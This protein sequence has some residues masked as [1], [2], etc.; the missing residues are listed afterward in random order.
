[1]IRADDIFLGQIDPAKLAS[2]NNIYIRFN[3]GRFIRNRE[4]K[5]VAT[6][7]VDKKTGSVIR[8]NYISHT[9]N[10]KND[11]DIR[12]FSSISTIEITRQ[13]IVEAVTSLDGDRYTD[14]TVIS[15]VWN[16]VEIS[17]PK[18]DMSPYTEVEACIDLPPEKLE[19]DRLYIVQ[20]PEF[21]DSKSDPRFSPFAFTRI[22][23][24]WKERHNI[25]ACWL[26]AKDLGF[27]GDRFI[28][29][30]SI[31]TTTT[32]SWDIQYGHTGYQEFT[33]LSG[34]IPDKPDTSYPEFT[35][36]PSKTP[37]FY[38]IVAVEGPVI[39][40]RFNI[41]MDYRRDL[42]AANY[43]DSYIYGN[44]KG[45]KA[46][47]GI[48]P[49]ETLEEYCA[50]MGRF[51]NDYVELFRREYY[52][53]LLYFH[54]P[55]SSW[56]PMIQSMWGEFARVPHI[57]YDRKMR[58]GDYVFLF[59]GEL[60]SSL[61]RERIPLDNTL[62]CSLYTLRRV[63]GDGYV[64]IADTT[65]VYEYRVPQYT[66]VRPLIDG[67][68][69]LEN[70]RWVTSHSLWSLEDVRRSYADAVDFRGR[71]YYYDPAAHV[72]IDERGAKRI[73]EMGRG[74][75]PG[76]FYR[77]IDVETMKTGVIYRDEDGRW[78][79]GVKIIDSKMLNWVD[80]LSGS[81][82]EAY[83]IMRYLLSLYITDE[84]L[85][86]HKLP[87]MVS[88]YEG[89]EVVRRYRATGVVEDMEEV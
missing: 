25:P 12:L 43:Q 16:T 13:G 14:H 36:P 63:Y 17:H 7:A 75:I 50:R 56:L 8:V 66:L 3:L 85:Y 38:R 88:E 71:R 70:M 83:C 60:D 23:R 68:P 31:L 67:V 26:V 40:V 41:T 55:Q 51:P 86:I 49:G 79:N 37:D 87:V 28:V 29:D 53:N 2:N 77:T 5:P 62:A 69:L 64:G 89:K 19:P 33:A 34:E 61:W 42:A 21:L 52:G 4:V 10:F 48:I 58:L 80:D 20:I 73:W 35:V 39:Y 84:A 78:C 24:T 82:V 46:I 65:G 27:D 6:Y 81:E 15:S 22:D 57:L 54:P 9:D 45:G 76:P 72:D 32:D 74:V 1:M 11:D 59:V 44:L 30:T 47:A 18:I